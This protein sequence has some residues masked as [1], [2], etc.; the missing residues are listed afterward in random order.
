[1][2]LKF[3]VRETHGILDPVFEEV[4]YRYYL[5]GA[6][7]RQTRSTH[8]FLYKEVIEKIERSSIATDTLVGEFTGNDIDVEFYSDRVIITELY[9]EDDNNPQFTSLSLPEAKKL[10]LEWQNA[11]KIWYDSRENRRKD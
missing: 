7:L 8:G 9:P 3:T 6:F 2:N 10:L 5:I 4:D 1:M 11:L